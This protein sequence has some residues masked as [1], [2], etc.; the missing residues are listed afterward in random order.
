MDSRP[1]DV[2]T[3][4]RHLFDPRGLPGQRRKPTLDNPPRSVRRRH[5]LIAAVLSAAA[6]IYGSL[7]PFQ[8][9]SLSVSEA[10]RALE[11][12]WAAGLTS[13]SSQ[14]VAINVLVAV[15]LA[16]SLMG[17]LLLRCR[18]N[19]A[20]LAATVATL[21]ICFV[22]SLGVE[23]GQFWL[24]SRVSSLRDIAAQVLGS[25]IGSMMW[26]LAGPALTDRLDEFIQSREPAKRVS[27]LLHAYP[28]GL[29]IWSL[30]PFDFVTS[31]DE[32]A[33][34][35][36]RGQIEVVPFTYQ[37]PTMFDLVYGNVVQTVLYVPIGIWS[38]T[39]WVR[40]K[41]AFRNTWSALAICIAGVTTL[42]LLQLLVKGRY[43]SSRDILLGTLGAA[44]GIWGITVWRRRQSIATR[45]KDETAVRTAGFWIV[46]SAAYSAILTVVSWAPFEITRDRSQIRKRLQDFVDI[47]FRALQS[48]GSDVGSL[49]H[50]VRSLG[51]YIPLG[52]LA[53]LAVH[54][55]ASSAR[56]RFAAGVAAMT[57]V[58]AVALVSELA[59]ILIPAR[60]PDL[61]EVMLR[62]LGGLIGFGITTVI[63][64][65]W[66]PGST[67][68]VPL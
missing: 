15:P 41:S 10:W 68:D 32:I 21:G 4:G 19:W 3:R 43:T 35:Y 27:W 13:Y 5:Y 22:V 18:G 58:A 25:V 17:A 30:L 48:S 42:E 12:L 26:L 56:M 60:T 7:L 6:L 28:I 44:L 20:M 67:R 33:Q 57:A 37:F 16:Y 8:F 55:A 40:R 63:V 39:A 59:Q 36:V 46:L 66:N 11:D 47:P 65:R 61:T 23:C 45:S 50:V 64:I 34:K 2:E 1:T 14:D 24:D 9:G 38:V 31:L 52:A 49:F 62:S 51:W 54:R 29:L 53:A